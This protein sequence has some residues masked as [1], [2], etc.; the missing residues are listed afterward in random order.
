MLRTF[1]EAL[2]MLGVGA[3]GVYGAV[4]ALRWLT[5][6]VVSVHRKGK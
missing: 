6:E 4:L 2:L 1:G 5:G 3:L